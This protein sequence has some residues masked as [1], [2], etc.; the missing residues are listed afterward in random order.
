MSFMCTRFLSTYCRQFFDTVWSMKLLDARLSVCLSIRDVNSREITF[1]GSRVAIP[2]SRS[3][4]DFAG[5]RIYYRH[6]QSWIAGRGVEGVIAG[7]PPDAQ[8]G[9]PKARCWT[10]PYDRPTSNRCFFLFPIEAY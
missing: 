4:L 8:Y 10:R 3:R 9:R 7:R 2:G 1:P 6:D 5:V